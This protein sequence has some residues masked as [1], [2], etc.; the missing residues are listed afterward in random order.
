[1]KQYG[2][3]MKNVLTLKFMVGTYVPMKNGE[4]NYSTS[5][6]QLIIIDYRNERR[7]IYRIYQ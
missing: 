1:M 7:V 6:K 2:K 5:Q 4:I 3:F